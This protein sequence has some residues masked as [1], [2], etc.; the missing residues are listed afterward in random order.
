MN[1]QTPTT[2]RKDAEFR[3]LCGLP[4]TGMWK[5]I[6][7]KDILPISLNPNDEYI[8][9]LLLKVKNNLELVVGGL[10][11][12]DNLDYIKCSHG[13][14]APLKYYYFLEK[15][16][17]L[18][19]KIHQNKYATRLL[20]NNILVPT[21]IK[22]TISCES[23][24][25]KFIEKILEKS[26]YNYFWDCNLEKIYVASTNQ[27]VYSEKR[28]SI[29]PEIAQIYNNFWH[30]PDWVIISFKKIIHLSYYYN[31]NRLWR[32][33]I[34]KS[35][36]TYDSESCWNKDFTLLDKDFISAVFQFPILHQKILENECQK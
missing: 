23:F 14:L 27:V 19:D 26:I 28:K 25:C 35:I 4:S 1:D 22:C 21:S 6:S 33:K 32:Y 34:Q 30:V 9:L 16:Y 5:P 20:P 12:I 36:C 18:V 2:H 29:N 11:C 24:R 10:G 13:H 17:P 8:K 31:E 7:A 3:K 15:L